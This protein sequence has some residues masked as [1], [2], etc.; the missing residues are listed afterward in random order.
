MTAPTTAWGRYRRTIL[1]ITTSHFQDTTYRTSWC[2]REHEVSPDTSH[3][4]HPAHTP[5]RQEDPSLL[6]VTSTDVIPNDNNEDGGLHPPSLALIITCATF[7]QLYSSRH[8]LQQTS[9][10]EGI[11]P[12][13]CVLQV[14]GPTF[15]QI[16][17]VKWFNSLTINNHH[18][19]QLISPCFTTSL[20]YSTSSTTY[21]PPLTISNTV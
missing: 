4:H 20:S 17:Q 9:T 3:H 19:K 21:K 1:H 12:R 8:V 2:G 13:R 16:K 11:Y 15:P 10:P 18:T 14:T 7:L 6:L 5:S